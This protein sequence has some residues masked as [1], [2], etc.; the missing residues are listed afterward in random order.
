MRPWPPLSKNADGTALIYAVE[1]FASDSDEMTQITSISSMT[2]N[3][4]S[5]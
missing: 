1:K 3:C 4:S 5:R 2:W